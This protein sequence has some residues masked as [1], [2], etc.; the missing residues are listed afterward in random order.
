MTT[1]IQAADHYAF[2]IMPIKGKH[3][4]AAIKRWGSFYSKVT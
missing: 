4:A 3:K 1:M 2:T